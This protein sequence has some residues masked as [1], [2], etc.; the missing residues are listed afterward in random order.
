MDPVGATPSARHLSNQFAAVLK[1][2]QMPPAPFDSVMDST[3]SFTLRTL[4]MLP[5][6]VLESQFQAFRFSL[7]A[8]FGNPPLLS[9]SKRCGKEFLRRHT[10]YSSPVSPETQIPVSLPNKVPKAFAVDSPQRGT[11]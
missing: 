10:S 1:K 5:W 7:K 3:Q 11:S 6:D 4:K 8:A 2:V 9:Q